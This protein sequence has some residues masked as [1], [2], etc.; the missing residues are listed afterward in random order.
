[1]QI[2]KDNRYFVKIWEEK[3]AEKKCVHER[4]QRVYNFIT[5]FYG[6]EMIKEAILFYQNLRSNGVV[7]DFSNEEVDMK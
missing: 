2:N 4:L 6:E 3:K 5:N 1:M 7:R